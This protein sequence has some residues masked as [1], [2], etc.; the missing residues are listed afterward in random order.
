M[1][2]RLRLNPPAAAP[3]PPLPLQS[4]PYPLPP[5]LPTNP[6]VD[7]TYR[8]NSP[9]PFSLLPAPPPF[10]PLLA[11]SLTFMRHLGRQKDRYPFDSNHVAVASLARPLRSSEA[12]HCHCCRSLSTYM[13]DSC[14]GRVGLISHGRFCV[15]VTVAAAL[16]ISTPASRRAH[17]A[18]QCS[19]SSSPNL[20]CNPLIRNPEANKVSQLQLLQHQLHPNI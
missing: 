11:P 2:V 6:S 9:S 10:S 1:D 5:C 17:F 4:L 3:A 19:H 16:S 7:N 12:A 15:P 8:P 20:T 13:Q 18:C 14:L